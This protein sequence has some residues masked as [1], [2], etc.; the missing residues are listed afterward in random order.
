MNAALGG[1]CGAGAGVCSGAGVC[2]LAAA[3]T[4][5]QQ[6]QQQRRQQQQQQREDEAGANFTA[7]P[8]HDF[9][10]ALAQ[11]GRGKEEVHKMLLGQVRLF[12]DYSDET[13]GIWMGVKS[14]C[15]HH[16]SKNYSRDFAKLIRERDAESASECARI[17]RL[18]YDGIVSDICA[19]TDS[20]SDDCSSCGLSP[21]SAQGSGG[22][23]V[24]DEEELE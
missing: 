21:D 3:S 20:D 16:E 10:M 15:V 13:M 19:A 8:M 7:L 12:H 17:L 23:T 14:R 5:R 4:Q 9:V 6:Q 22:D 2:I 18:R 24:V 1:T 11:L